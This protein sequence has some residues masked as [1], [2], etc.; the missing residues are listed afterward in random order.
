MGADGTGQKHQAVLP[1]FRA[2]VL[3]VAFSG[4][5]VGYVKGQAG[6]EFHRPGEIQ[7][8]QGNALIGPF[9][10]LQVQEAQEGQ[11]ELLAGGRL[12]GEAPG[13]GAGPHVQLP[14][15]V[16]EADFSQI[17]SL[18]VHAQARHQP[19]GGGNHKM[20]PVDDAPV[21]FADGL[22]LVDAVGI[23]APERIDAAAFVKATA[24]PHGFIGQGEHRFADPGI[25]W[26]EALLDHLPG[27]DLEIHIRFFCHMLLPHTKIW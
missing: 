23:H 9:P 21:A 25:G 27:I 1:R 22:D 24:H 26:V 5:L 14:A 3:P 19:V 18:P 16:P 7:G 4:P 20:G 15:E 12:P 10:A 8:F 6:E 17:Q 2:G 13:Q 11:P